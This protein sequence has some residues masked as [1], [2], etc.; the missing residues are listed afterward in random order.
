MGLLE[1]TWFLFTADHGESLGERDIY[2]SHGHNC[3]APESRVPLV[4]TSFFGEI[5]LENRSV[6]VSGIYCRC[7]AYRS[8]TSRR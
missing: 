6:R 5:E 8:R 4:V 7:D 1:N 3:Y 2:L